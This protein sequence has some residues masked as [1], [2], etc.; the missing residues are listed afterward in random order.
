MSILPRRARRAEMAVSERELS[1]MTRE[2]DELHESTFP[3]V[4]A[5]IDEMAVSLGRVARVASTRRGFVVGAAGA[6]A[7]GAVAACSSGSSGAPSSSPAATP[8]ARTQTYTGDL[9][10]VALATAA[11][12]LAV[13]AY[14]GALKKAGAGQLGT[15]PPAVDTFVRTVMRQHADHAQAWNAVLS[16]AGKPTVNGAP[17]RVTPE[18]LSM[19]DAAGSVPD[20]AKLALNLENT[21]AQTY[22]AATATVSDPGGIMTA[23]TIQP[24]E[25]MHAAI[26]HF[27][28]GQYPVPDSFIGTTG[29]LKP[30]DLT[31]A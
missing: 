22:T 6:V 31:V 28:L 3:Q 20:V 8:G 2:L 24:V 19:F 17:L 11:E 16:K 1:E 29:S 27:I 7:F 9:R 10:V 30:D 12:N 25:T 14:A 18:Q 4:R 13:T 26:L 21:A 15:V 5:L 23:A